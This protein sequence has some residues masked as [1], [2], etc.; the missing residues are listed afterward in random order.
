MI[1]NIAD[2]MVYTEYE[3]VDIVQACKVVEISSG[4]SQ[5]AST[6]QSS[7]TFTVGI[8]VAA[9]NVDFLV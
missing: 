3:N 5:S 6:D 8:D 4:S 1:H 7:I 2:L 9:A